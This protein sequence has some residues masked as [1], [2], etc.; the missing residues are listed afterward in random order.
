MQ[1]EWTT[2]QIR[3]LNKDN[4]RF[5]YESGLSVKKISDK[6]GINETTILK[7]LRLYGIKMRPQ[8]RYKK[9]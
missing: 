4:L 8:Y 9:A 6:I 3:A 5:L 1:K 2:E 7:R